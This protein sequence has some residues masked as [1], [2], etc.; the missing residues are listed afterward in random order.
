MCARALMFRI[1]DL[2]Y[3]TVPGTLKLRTPIPGALMVIV[4]VMDWPDVFVVDTSDT[5]TL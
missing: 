5:R 1:R 3:R 2:C 4:N